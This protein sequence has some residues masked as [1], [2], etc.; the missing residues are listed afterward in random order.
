VGL[1]D[2][3]DHANDSTLRRHN[4]EADRPVVTRGAALVTA[5]SLGASA[6]VIAVITALLI[7]TR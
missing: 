5:V 1:V 2:R 6:I 3:W 7:I 4:E